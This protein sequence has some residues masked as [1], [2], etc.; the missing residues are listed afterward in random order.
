[1]SGRTPPLAVVAL[2]PWTVDCGTPLWWIPIELLE[3]RPQNCCADRSEHRAG[4]E[5]WRLGTVSAI[6]T[7]RSNQPLAFLRRVPA[8]LVLALVVLGILAILVTVFALGVHATTEQ[9]RLAGAEGRA[10]GQ[11]FG[12]EQSG[13]GCRGEHYR[14]LAECGEDGDF[15]CRAHWASFA[16]ACYEAARL[17]ADFCSSASV[18]AGQSALP[19]PQRR[20]ELREQCRVQGMAHRSRCARVLAVAAHHCQ[21]AD[22]RAEL[23]I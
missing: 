12:A 5:W 1:M 22:A 20:L 3:S 4:E 23:P 16:A 13:A 9:W 21:P 19:A 7:L 11:A 10:R 6:V 17:E 14:R 2:A 15:S 8:R 18:F